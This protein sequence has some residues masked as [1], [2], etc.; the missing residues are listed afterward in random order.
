LVLRLQENRNDLFDTGFQA[1]V[2]TSYYL[3]LSNNPYLF[4]TPAT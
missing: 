1:N 4:R 2:I 3:R